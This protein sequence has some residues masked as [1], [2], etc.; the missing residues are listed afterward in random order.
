MNTISISKVIEYRYVITGHEHYAFGVDKK[1][2]NLKTG[3]E[4]KK[5]INCRSV[6]FWIGKQFFSLNKLRP[7]LKRPEHYGLPF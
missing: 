5:T 3:R 6:G 4:I 1:L 2:Y 7:L